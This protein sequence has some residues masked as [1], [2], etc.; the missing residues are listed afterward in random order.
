M[1]LGSNTCISISRVHSTIDRSSLP[2]LY[3]KVWDLPSEE[4]P[5]PSPPPSPPIISAGTP[6]FFSMSISLAFSSRSSLISL[7]VG[8]SFTVAVVLMALALSAIQ[9]KTQDHNRR[10]SVIKRVENKPRPMF[11]VSDLQ[12][13]LIQGVNGEEL[14]FQFATFYACL[15][16]KSTR[17]CCL[18]STRA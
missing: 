17:L 7:S 12:Y 15:R 16:L 5:P 13:Q 9:S 18:K 2:C 6:P 10:G 1:G 11:S 14:E 8:L 4:A 3:M